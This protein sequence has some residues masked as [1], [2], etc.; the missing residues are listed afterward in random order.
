MRMKKKNDDELR[1]SFCGRS[2]S[3]VE[4]IMPGLN[5]CICNDCAEQANELAHEYLAKARKTA[6]NAVS[7]SLKDIP[8][9]KEIN[10][11]LNQYVIGQDSAKKYLSVAVYNH[12]KRLNQTVDDVEIEKSNIIIVGPTGTGKTLL[13]KTIAKLLKVPFAIVDATVLTEAGYVGEDIESLLTRLLQACD[14]NV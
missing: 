5:G 13:A 12:Y 8:T 6:A 14:Y 4:L 10:D 3:E 11:Y 7:E 9:P 1:C 2:Q